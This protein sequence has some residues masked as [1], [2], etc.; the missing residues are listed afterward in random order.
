MYGVTISVTIYGSDGQGY[1]S[2]GLIG[3]RRHCILCGRFDMIDPMM[4]DPMVGS[5]IG[6]TMTDPTVGSM[7]GPMMTDPQLP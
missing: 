4:I 6:P 2:V 5:M 7:V 3:T 1:E